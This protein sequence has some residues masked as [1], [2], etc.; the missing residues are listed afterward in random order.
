MKD[1]DFSKI[2]SFSKLNLF[3]RCQKAYYF[4]Y[5]D[6]EISP[7]KKEF[8]KP[9]DYKTKG[10][11]V[12]DAITLFYHLPEEER[13]F[14]NL[15]SCLQQAWFS[16]TNPSKKPP[17]G[18]D[19]GFRDIKHERRVYIESLVLL[20]NFFE[21]SETCPSFFH[22]PT[23]NIRDS[24]SDYEELITPLDE[25]FS[26]S[27]KFDRIDELKD[28]NLRVIDFKTSSNNQNYFQLEFY[29]LLAELNFNKKVKT[30]SF[31]Y[32]KD[33][34]VKDYDVFKVGQDEIK[35]K[36]GEKIKEIMETKNFLPRPSRLCKHCDFEEVCPIFK[37][38]YEKNSFGSV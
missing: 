24:F 29:K 11:A 26:I 15:K 2:F 38:I 23:K 25:K 33:K 22:I 7:R 9:R 8:I 27:G 4:Y 37:Q 32:L 36:V 17:L 6:P 19:G 31:Y 13:S 16:E 10:Q 1:I 28:G 35:R 3:E 20:R 5:L 21:M 14:E 18:K 12:H 34:K 30:V